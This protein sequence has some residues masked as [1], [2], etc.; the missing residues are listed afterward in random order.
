[1]KLIVAFCIWLPLSA[2]PQMLSNLTGEVLEDMPFFNAAFIKENKVK[3]F[4][5]HYSTKYDHDIIRPN[6]DAYVYEFDRLGQLVRKYK[7]HLGDTLLSTYIYDYKG[8]VLIHRESNKLGYYEHRYTYDN[9]NRVVKMELRR[10]KEENLHK[11]SFELDESKTVAVEKYEYIP[12]EGMDYKKVC[13]NGADRVYRT[14]FYYFNSQQKLSKV[15]SALY[16]GS[17]RT[18]VN[19]FYDNEGRLEEVK[20]ISKANHAHITRKVF[21]Y[22]D[23][24]NTLSRHIYRNDKLITEDQLVYAEGTRLWKAV[25]N[26]EN[27][28]AMLTIL[29]FTNYQKY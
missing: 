25:I 9:R 1:M 20:T 21:T 13:Y 3:S 7:I 8:N 6:N 18:E 14:E 12:L 24:G 29:E 19:Y 17:G 26:R 23:Y 4:K 22:D 28:G 15:E 2:M 11:L 16:N 10:E 27:A 5:G